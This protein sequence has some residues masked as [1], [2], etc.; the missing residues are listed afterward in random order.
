LS[1]QNNLK[2]VGFDFLDRILVP[3][4]DHNLQYYL[5]DEDRP[6]DVIEHIM[7]I[8]VP[9]KD[10]QP[11][12]NEYHEKFMSQTGV[13]L[14]E[15]WSS[16]E[17][18]Q[19]I[20]DEF[21]DYLVTHAESEDEKDAFLEALDEEV[22][23]ELK[24][25]LTVAGDDN[26]KNTSAWA[27]DFVTHSLFAATFILNI[28]KGNLALAL[29][30][31]YGVLPDITGEFRP[32]PPSDG[33]FVAMLEE[34]L[35]WVALRSQYFQSVLE[36]SYDNM[37]DETHE[38]LFLG[39][40]CD[41]VLWTR[42][43]C[44]ADDEH[45]VIYDKTDCR[46]ALE[47]LLNDDLENNNIE[48]RVA[49]FREAFAD[50]EQVGKYDAVVISGLAPYIWK[51]IR[52]VLI[53]VKKLL[54]PDGQILLDLSVKCLS[55]LFVGTTFPWPAKEMYLPETFDQAVDNID[56]ICQ[57]AGLQ[58]SEAYYEDGTEDSDDWCPAGIAFTL[59]NVKETEE[60]EE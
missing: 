23:P 15:S 60:A 14:E 20:Y 16:E 19:I 26:A 29:P 28:A 40:G 34:S 1:V 13:P 25:L 53:G 50:P 31:A 3:G 46:S 38:I 41:G 7:K 48:F 2:P 45:I 24:P 11:V 42:G 30:V 55:Y 33:A 10:L 8:T 27:K 4:T 35:R 57:D 32:I 21:R 5:Q 43:F 51:D 56:T 52:Q 22:W 6:C 17:G 9:G 54:K 58:L 47:Q 49:D 18:L 36:D 39:G 37:E 59:V 12:S 44:I